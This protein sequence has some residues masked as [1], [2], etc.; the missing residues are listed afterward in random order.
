MKSD[1]IIYFIPAG[2]VVS[3]VQLI[4]RGCACK[5]HTE[6]VS[7]HVRYEVHAGNCT[8]CLQNDPLCVQQDVKLC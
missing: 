5:F 1:Q 6:C 3:E 7:V 8:T 4:S 2:R